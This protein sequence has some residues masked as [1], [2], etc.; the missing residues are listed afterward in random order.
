MFI[1]PYFWF[2]NAS[3]NELNKLKAPLP[4]LELTLELIKLIKPTILPF[5]KRG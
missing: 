2:E 4:T 5:I 1:K 3:N